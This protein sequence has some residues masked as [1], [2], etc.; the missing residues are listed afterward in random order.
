MID[1]LCFK[2][3]VDAVF[4]FGKW[5]ICKFHNLN[6]RC[7]P[8]AGQGKNAISL[9]QRIPQFKMFLV[10]NLTVVDNY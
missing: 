1:I 4:E 2:I 5:R 9:F 8:T 7:V 3:S 10:S 6:V